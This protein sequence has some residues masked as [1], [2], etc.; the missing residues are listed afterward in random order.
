MFAIG[1]WSG[2]M[3]HQAGV[4]A[5]LGLKELVYPERLVHTVLAFIRMGRVVLRGGGTIWA[6]VVAHKWLA[7]VTHTAAVHR[8]AVL[9]WRTHRVPASMA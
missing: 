3:V 8:K 1:A 6:P 4:A 2:A 7:T 9:L 5:W